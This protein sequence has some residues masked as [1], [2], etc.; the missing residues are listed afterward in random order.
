M[1]LFI[2]TVS[3]RNSQDCIGE[4]VQIDVAPYNETIKLGAGGN[5]TSVIA[6]IAGIFEQIVSKCFGNLFSHRD[7]TDW[8]HLVHSLLNIG[9]DHIANVIVNCPLPQFSVLFLLGHYDAD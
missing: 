3:I 6:T 5:Q 4:R 9:P 2:W 7:V 8:S 1:I